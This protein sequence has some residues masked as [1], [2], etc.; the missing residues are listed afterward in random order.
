MNGKKVVKNVILCVMKKFN[1]KII[2]VL[3]ALYPVPVFSQHEADNWYF[4]INAAITFS[5]N[6][7]SYL[8]GS[9]MITNEGC[10]SLSDSAGNLLFYSDGSSIWDR[11]HTVMPNGTGL[12]ASSTCTQAALF[13]PHPG[14]DS[15]FYIFTPPDEFAVPGYFSYSIID[16]TLN[17]GNGDVIN[18]NT[19]LFSPSTEKVTACRH[20]NGTDIWVIGHSYNNADFYAYIITA[21][22]INSTPVIS[23]AGA[24]H[25]SGTANKEGNMKASPC[26]DKIAL[27]VSDSAFVELFDFDNATG[28][29]S[30]AIHLGNFTP[31]I[32]W[33]LYGLE[34]SPDGSRLYVTQENPAVLVQYNLLAG[35]PAAIIASADTIVMYTANWLKF[36]GLQTGPN[37]KI[38]V[39][40][41][42]NDFLAVINN[43][44]SLGNSC[45]FVDTAVQLGQWIY[46]SH[47]LPNFMSSFFCPL[48]TSVD[49]PKTNDLTTSIYPN[50]VH[51]EIHITVVILSLS[52]IEI[53]VFN[54][55][56][57]TILTKS[58]DK[59][60]PGS[61]ILKINAKDLKAGMYFI[62]TNNGKQYEIEKFMKE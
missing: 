57:Q 48:V 13:V 2:L 33:C 16:M 29:V 31:H 37:G 52:A 32:A 9:Q 46:C 36:S 11:T 4:G 50:P 62:E 23:T 12:N 28:I 59:L 56:G 38:Y 44:D 61:H 25:T 5:T 17:N 18:K 21:S 34:F 10:A 15:L 47:G 53:N 42:S 45:N 55:L 41:L 39:G 30:N 20:A 51:A 1:M 6:P 58:F 26:G 8:P 19:Q 40:R 24:V 14:N 60:H 22:G 43:P 35:S 27:V 49:N 54:Y 7:P 3:L